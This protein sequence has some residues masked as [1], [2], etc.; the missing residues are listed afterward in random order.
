MHTSDA[1]FHLIVRDL[2]RAMRDGLD[3]HPV[4]RKLV[5]REANDLYVSERA[6]VALYEL[7]QRV[8]NGYT[9][10]WL[11]GIE[12]LSIAYDGYVY[13]KDEAVEH[14]NIPWAYDERVPAEKLA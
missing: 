8:R 2:V 11:H 6:E 7:H 1:P 9:K 13:W 10:P 5:E 14:Y 4:D 3:L 12:H